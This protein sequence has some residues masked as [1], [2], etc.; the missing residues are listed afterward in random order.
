[1]ALSWEVFGASAALPRLLC[2]ARNSDA[3]ASPLHRPG[4]A[5]V[6]HQQAAVGQPRQCL[7]EEGGWRKD[8]VLPVLAG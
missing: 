2:H 3:G 7:K 5:A 6:V 8:D 1:M 4:T